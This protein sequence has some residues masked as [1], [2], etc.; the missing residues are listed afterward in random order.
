V[1]FFTNIRLGY[2][3]L[4]A[5]Y[6]VAYLFTVPVKKKANPFF[7]NCLKMK[8]PKLLS[9]QRIKELSFEFSELMQ[10]GQKTVWQI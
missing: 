4:P 1:V 2:K 9:R 7:S 10:F 8:P 3:S 6:A 5:K